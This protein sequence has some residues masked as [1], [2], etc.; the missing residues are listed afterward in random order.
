MGK[1]YR[2]PFLGAPGNSLDKPH[3]AV[4]AILQSK[5]MIL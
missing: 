2:V 5:Y 3:V 4:A 1:G